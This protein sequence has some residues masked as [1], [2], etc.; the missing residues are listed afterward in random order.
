MAK[1]YE[2]LVF[3][4]DFM[5]G[6]VMEDK[7]LCRELLECLLEHP[8]GELEEIQTEKQFQYMYD[9]KPIRLDVY[10]R[11][12]KAV[13]DTEM[14]NL[15]HKSLKQLELPMRSRSYQSLIDADILILLRGNCPNIHSCRDA[16]RIWK[17]R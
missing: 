17:L 11:D 12:K 14:Q 6:K 13:Y 10:T 4:D 1:N 15:N 3:T 5:F 16:K 7:E 8:V 2:D 9:G